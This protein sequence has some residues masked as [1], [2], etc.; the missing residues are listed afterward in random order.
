[1][2]RVLS[3]FAIAITFFSQAIYAQ[4][5]PKKIAL[6]IAIGKY[7]PS[8]GWNTLSSLNDVK[9]VKAALLSQGFDEKDIDTLKGEQATKAGMVKA[10]DR[11][12]A[13]AN[14][15]D[16]V[17]FHFSGHGQQ[18]FDKAPRK[19]ESDGYDESL[20]AYDAKLRY[21]PIKYQGQNHFT[22]DELGDKLTN[23]RKKIGANGSLLVLIDACH[24]GTATRG[25]EIAVARGS[26]E[27]IEP[28]G[29]NPDITESSADKND[30]FDDPNLLSNL[31]LISASSADQLNY[32]TKDNLK[33]GVGSLT[34]AFSR[35]ISEINGEI[36]Y[37]ILFEKIKGDIQGWKPFQNPQIEGNTS[38]QVLGGKYIKTSDWVSIT[39]WV[40]DKTIDMPRG[41][42]HS[43]ANGATFKLYPLE[44]IDYEKTEPSAIGEITATGISSSTGTLKEPLSN[45]KNNRYKAIF[46][47]QSFGD[48]TVIVKIALKDPATVTAIRKKLSEYK[49][50][51]LDKPN[52]DL[53]IM[54]YKNPSD[55][56]QKLQLV[57]ANDSVLWQR[58]WPA[59]AKNS[60]SEE[61]LDL[62][63]KSIRQYSRAQFLR[64]LHSA[65]DDPTFPDVKVEIIPG[66]V[67]KIG[68]YD[69]LVNRITLKDKTNK[70]GDIEF[71][72]Q[73][74]SQPENDGFVIRIKNNGDHDIYFSLLDI[75]PDNAV[76]V[77]YPAKNR[78]AGEYKVIP[79]KTYESAPI[80][81]VP[82]Y[83]KEFMK[84]LITRDPLDLR[85]IDSRSSSRG[86]GSSFESFYNETFKDESSTS[87]G[88]NDTGAIKID[89]IRIIPF[90]FDIVRKK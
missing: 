81:L 61:E 44:T 36:N 21:D 17:V 33:N 22:D 34:Y 76:A 84:I 8:S 69:S 74:D 56:V 13:R 37:D 30:M 88:G 59:N 85:G 19:D 35:A 53:S 58:S 10:I 68:R 45:R 40:D 63:W 2:L 15:G 46:D 54:P 73:L 43:I 60:L 86:K 49:Y 27:A 31:V 83:G 47:S 80:T 79:G 3:G 5:Q 67:K 12:I 29:Y 48:M 66:T 57:A 11:L 16:I 32:E 24:S 9:Y 71:K 89:E 75:M 6:I 38:Q 4:T 65:A 78:S 39:K 77:M 70:N 72:E 28:K 41:S 26:Q 1:M 20:V 14:E 82:P 18:V 7:E 50:I 55:N 51:Q 25:Q 42:I 23:L 62:V 52:A 90:T 87:R 64:G